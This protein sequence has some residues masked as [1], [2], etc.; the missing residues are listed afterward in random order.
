M[1]IFRM[2][3]LFFEHNRK[4]ISVFF[5]HIFFLLPLLSLTLS[6]CSNEKNEQQQMPPAPIHTYKTEAKDT[7]IILKAVGNVKAFTSVTI[8]SRVDGHIIRIH[9]LDGDTVEKGQVLY[10]IDP[11][12][13]LFSQK[14]AL[15][16]VASD[17]ASAELA[18]K[19]YIRYRELYEKDVI[20]KDEYEQKLT[21]YETARK[22]MEA[23]SAQADIAKR[24][25]KFTKVTSPINGIAG[26]TLLDEGNLIEADKDQLVVI[27]TIT[28]ASVDFYIPG[29]EI[30]RV[31]SHYIDDELP[32]FATPS[33]T[34]GKRIEGVL[35]FV[36]NWINPDTGMI[37]LSAHFPNKDKNLWPGMFVSI[38]LVLATQ[39]NAIR[40]PAQAVMRGP[41]GKFV[42][43]VSK[44]N[45]TMRPVTTGMRI[46]DDV[47]INKGLGPDE[48][49]VTDG[50]L[51]LF[52]NAPVQILKKNNTGNATK[53]NNP[54]TQSG[55]KS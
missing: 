42:Y 35:T 48:V 27:K 24:N 16:N 6:G 47:V 14:G 40:I 1:P 22:K 25:V 18:R 5:I 23:D 34:G 29:H 19:D 37:K 3:F 41:T 12:T 52:E 50:M 36:D 17:H 7:P 28:P 9:F 13:Y 51:R 30:D 10:T 4:N 20:S 53:T 44:E 26:S 31:R 39:E 15:A 54:P 8:K 21:A 49:I 43:V 46:D 45:A 11:E 38:D 55:D 32:V 2:S 33:G